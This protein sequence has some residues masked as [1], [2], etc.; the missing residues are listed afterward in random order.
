LIDGPSS[1]DLHF[2]YVVAGTDD[3]SIWNLVTF[4]KFQIIAAQP[5]HPKLFQIV[6]MVCTQIDTQGQHSA[7]A[8]TKRYLHIAEDFIFHR[9]SASR[10]D[11]FTY[12]GTSVSAHENPHT[13]VNQT[14]QYFDRFTVLHLE[15]LVV[16]SAL[17][18]YIPL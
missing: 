16:R 6:C 13:S 11:K 4:Q 5:L 9:Y 15:P 12:I 14:D 17:D 8:P 2:I 7:I 3:V 18:H 1:R 10:N